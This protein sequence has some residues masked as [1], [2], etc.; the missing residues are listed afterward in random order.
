MRQ[1]R[2]HD[3]HHHHEHH[4]DHDHSAEPTISEEY[5]YH[6]SSHTHGDHSHFN[7]S[8][9]THHDH[10]HSHD[11]H[12]DHKHSHGSEHAHDEDC[13][14]CDDGSHK[15]LMAR[16]DEGCPCCVASI[17]LDEVATA[18]NEIAKKRIRFLIN[19]TRKPP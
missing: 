4:H 8:R 3:H 16:S 9:K 11:D 7:L 15:K 18:L 10:G 19:W 1:F 2:S 12:H 6:L 14:D 5:S 13:G 17:D